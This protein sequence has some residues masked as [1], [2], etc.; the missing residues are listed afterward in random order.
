ML[1]GPSKCMKQI[2][3]I[4]HNRVKNPS[5]SEVEPVGYL[6]AWSRI[7]TLDYRE[8]IQLTIRAGLELGASEL[9]VRRSNHSATLP[10]FVQQ[11]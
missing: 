9:Q 11:S 10:P 2:I 4:K 6:Q 7:W 3:S 1:V 8:Q 5:W